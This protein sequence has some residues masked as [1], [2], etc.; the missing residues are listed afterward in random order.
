MLYGFIDITAA[1]ALKL[2]TAMNLVGSAF[3]RNLA[4]D[5]V[6]HIGG[7]STGLVLHE[8]SALA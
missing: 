4:I 6:G 1:Q 5:C 7:Q 2:T 3:Q 8:T